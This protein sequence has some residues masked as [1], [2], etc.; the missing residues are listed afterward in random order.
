MDFNILDYTE[1]IFRFCLKRLNSRTDAE[2][3]SQEIL[4]HILDGFSKREID[5]PEPYVWQ[6]AHNRYARKIDG[7]NKLN[8]REVFCGDIILNNIA[9]TGSVEDELILR[10]EHS[11]VFNAIHSLSASYRDILLDHYVGE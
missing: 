2:D 1:P 4:L 10:E 7:K 8:K 9:N 5:N 11:S 3:L 6:I